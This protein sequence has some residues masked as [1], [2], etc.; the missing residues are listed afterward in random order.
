M[1]NL[2][3]KLLGDKQLS[4]KQKVKNQQANCQVTTLFKKLAKKNKKKKGKRQKPQPEC[5]FDEINPYS[6]VEHENNLHAL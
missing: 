5:L 2:T 6:L 3:S 1:R 4:F